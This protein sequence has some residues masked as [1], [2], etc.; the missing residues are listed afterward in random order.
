MDVIIMPSTASLIPQL[1]ATYPQFA[2]KLAESFLWSPSKQTVYYTTD[3]ADYGFLLHELSHGLLGHADYSRDIELIAMERDAWDKAL[4]IAKDYTVTINDDLIQS[5]LDTYRD[6]LHARSTCPRCKAVGL[7]IKKQ[8]YT[9]PAC[10]H[11]WRVNEARIC[12][13]RRSAVA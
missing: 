9:C 4:E 13:L 3:D 11:P 2:F 7:Q 10:R 5:T 12:A 8:T 1:K 6:W